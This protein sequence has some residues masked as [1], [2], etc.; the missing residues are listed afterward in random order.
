MKIKSFP[1]LQRLTVASEISEA[2]RKTNYA[3]LALFSSCTKECKRVGIT[4]R[5]GFWNHDEERGTAF[6]PDRL[7]EISPCWSCFTLYRFNQYQNPSGVDWKRPDSEEGFVS[8]SC[9]KALAHVRL[10]RR[11]LELEER[12]E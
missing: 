4:H 9:A 11:L 7:Q 1:Q 10:K 3:K 8:G 6:I 12:C 2:R 5:L